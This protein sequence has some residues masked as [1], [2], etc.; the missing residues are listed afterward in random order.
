MTPYEI[1]ILLHYHCSM[2]DYHGPSR[3]NPLYMETMDN[4]IQL[5]LLTENSKMEE[6]PDYSPTEKLHIYVEALQQVPLPV[7]RM[8]GNWPYKH[9]PVADIGANQAMPFPTGRTRKP[10]IIS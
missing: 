6:G 4:F 2:G 7:Y 5:G 8:P 1:E 9:G 3:G 10:D